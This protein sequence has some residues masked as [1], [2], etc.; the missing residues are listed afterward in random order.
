L[1]PV[2][3]QNMLRSLWTNYTVAS[4]WGANYRHRTHPQPVQPSSHHYPS[5]LNTHFRTVNHPCLVP[6]VASA[7][8]RQWPNLIKLCIYVMFRSTTTILTFCHPNNT[9]WR[10]KRRDVSMH[11][12][13]ERNNLLIHVFINLFTIC[14]LFNDEY[15]FGLIKK[16]CRDNG[17][18]IVSNVE[19]SDYDP[20]SDN[21]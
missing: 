12:C 3:W 16:T 5:S 18:W 4:G 15:H 13:R 7:L 6:C 17:Y 21:T 9:R 8:Y 20:V 2:I 14:N 11:S 10:L 19:G 1:C